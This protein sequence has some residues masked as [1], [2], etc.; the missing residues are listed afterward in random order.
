MT[1]LS[2]ETRC[3]VRSCVLS[4]KVLSV[5]FFNLLVDFLLEIPTLN[6][7]SY[8]YWR[9][10]GHFI[11]KLKF[12]TRTDYSWKTLYCNYVHALPVTSKQTWP[13]WPLTFSTLQFDLCLSTDP[14][15][16]PIPPRC[17]VFMLIRS[18]YFYY[19]NFICILILCFH[20][21]G[22]RFSRA[23][24]EWRVRSKTI[25]GAGS[26]WGNKP[27]QRTPQT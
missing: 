24:L 15:L 19:R 14:S 13:G 16:R 26:L 18:I 23:A 6:V 10:W 25:N 2:T 20:G 8:K 27:A 7:N 21:N 11:F 12:F 22:L 4:L 3:D 17:R 5:F 9:V 1:N